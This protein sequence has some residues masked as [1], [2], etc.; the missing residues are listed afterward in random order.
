MKFHTFTVSI[1][2]FFVIIIIHVLI[3][4]NSNNYFNQKS[5]D[6]DYETDYYSDNELVFD[7]NTI[8]NL[9]KETLERTNNKPSENTNNLENNSDDI[10][11]ELLKYLDL[12]EKESMDLKTEY[13]NKRDDILA[14]NSDNTEKNS[15]FTNEKTDLSSYFTKNKI[16][17]SQ[18]NNNIMAYDDLDTNYALFS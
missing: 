16:D 13:I 10:R 7:L 18:L 11:S 9:K 1:V 15:D 8:D 12:E 2:Y 17:D 6:T 5:D 3:K 4:N 14:S